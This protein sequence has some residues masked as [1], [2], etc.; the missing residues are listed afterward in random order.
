MEPLQAIP[1]SLLFPDLLVETRLLNDHG[2]LA[3]DRLEQFK[4]TLS[5][6]VVQSDALQL[7]HSDNLVLAPQR[8]ADGGADLLKEEALSMVQAGVRHRIGGQQGHPV[9]DDSVD[10]SS[11]G[12]EGF[13]LPVLNFP[14]FDNDGD[15]FFIVFFSREDEKSV[16]GI[17]DDEDEI[18]DLV[19]KLSEIMDGI[20]LTADFIQDIKNLVGPFEGGEFHLELR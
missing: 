9:A 8:H 2:H 3:A 13:L 11:A 10:D 17:N 18:H 20:Q 7:N 15:E 1:H 5:E 6:L 16:V 4:V 14:R 12:F 19:E